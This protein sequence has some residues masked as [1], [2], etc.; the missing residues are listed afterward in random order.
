MEDYISIKEVQK[1]LG[2]CTST[3][4]KI[5]H[6]ESFPP[7]KKQGLKSYIIPKQALLMWCKKQGYE[8]EVM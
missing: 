6:S 7:L 5:V 3:A 2:C 4:Y 1:M 8:I